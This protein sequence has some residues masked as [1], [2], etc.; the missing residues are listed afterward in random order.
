M[1]RLG[2]LLK[3]ERTRRGLTFKQVA[4]KNGVS[5]KFLI[6]VESGTRIIADDKARSILKSMGMT[7]QTE[8]DFTLDDIASTV[9][10]SSAGVVAKPLQKKEVKEKPSS[11]EQNSSIFMD[12]LSSILKHVPVM[13]AVMKEV[14]H[15]LLPVLDG[16]IENANPDKVYYLLA[17]D[18]QMR[19]FRVMK[20]DH[21]LV[22]PASSPVD[23]AIMV[24]QT[25]EGRVMRKVV[26][27]AGFQVMLQTYDLSLQCEIKNL[28]EISCVG[29]CVRVEV[30]L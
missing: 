23:N 27:M 8:A 9:D 19:G 22:V 3:L 4:K 17:P 2:D 29:R 7:H 12:A 10:L 18:D 16:K 25:K 5:E 14:S 24:L 28:N 21:V 13:N 1:S 11:N 30:D 20:G 6:E 15:K 26:K